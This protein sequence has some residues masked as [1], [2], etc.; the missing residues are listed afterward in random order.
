MIQTHALGGKS[1]AERVG[2]RLRRLRNA[3]KAP[4]EAGGARRELFGEC[5][6]SNAARTALSVADDTS[7]LFRPV[8]RTELAA[9]P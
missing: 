7:V 6:R 2:N 5:I 4:P 8:P 9:G 3:E 1:A